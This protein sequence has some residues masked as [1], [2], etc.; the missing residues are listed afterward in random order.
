MTL[1]EFFAAIADYLYGLWPIRIVMQWEQGIRVTS[2]KIHTTSLT[3]ENGLFKT[4]L[5][6]FWPIIGSIECEDSNI[7]VIE[8]DL[9]TVR[10]VDGSEVTFSLG[11]KFRIRDAAAMHA[12][13]H[14][15]E[16][17][18]VDAIRSAAGRAAMSL[19]DVETA[20]SD[21]AGLVLIESKRNMYGWGIKVISVDLITFTNAQALRLIMDD[22]G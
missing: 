19:L 7:E 15:F 10:L 13:I 9:Q 11:T 12:M 8:T 17:S 5:H 14:D 22:R 20:R 3:S 1:G 21:L 18:V 2:G 6:F 4:G 16:S